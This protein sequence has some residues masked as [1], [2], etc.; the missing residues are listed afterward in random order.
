V[1]RSPILSPLGALIGEIREEQR[2]RLASSR[3][4]AD[5]RE[6]RA[7]K[8]AGPEVDLRVETR[9]MTQPVRANAAYRLLPMSLVLH[10]AFLLAV[11]V[12]PW[13]TPGVL[14]VPASATRVILFEPVAIPPPL[15]P[16]APR[17]VA[18]SPTRPRATPPTP[19]TQAFTAPVETPD[20]V[21]PEPGTDLGVPADDP[22]GVE[23]GVPGGVVGGVVG[24]LP[25]R[26]PVIEP[27]RVG[28]DIKEPAKRKHVDPVYPDV[29]IV[30]NV[31]GIVVLE[32]RIGPQGQVTA[33][34]VLRGIP[35]LNDAAVAAVKQWVYTPTLLNG[36]PMPVV[37]TV[38][39]QFAL[40]ES[41]PPKRK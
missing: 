29:A 4:T 16:P 24:G 14:P 21:T 25:E 28:G 32:C 2:L 12:V 7:P 35:L 40:D 6:V 33:V 36:V 10:A 17:A 19:Q 13:L 27:V 20:Q 9:I 26:P 8:T 5:D 31:Q 3:K 37:M 15:P 38:T 22:G 39:V 23:G 30:A 34:K 1:G 11:I 41:R 18:A